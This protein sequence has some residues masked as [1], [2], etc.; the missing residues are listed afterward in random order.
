V[1]LSIC[2][3]RKP[4]DTFGLQADVLCIL[5]VSDAE[6]NRLSKA[7]I[8]RPLREF[9]FDHHF[10]FHPVGVLVC[11]RCLD[12]WR[13]ILFEPVQPLAHVAQ[14]FSI[15]ATACVAYV[16]KAPLRVKVA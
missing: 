9:Y 10:W 1:F 7:M 13:P 15:E 3:A 16:V 8:R 5:V 12:E 6:E 2:I 4:L 14:S 11:A